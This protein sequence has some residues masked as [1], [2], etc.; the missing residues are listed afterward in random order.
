VPSKL[1]G[2]MRHLSK[3]IVPSV[4]NLCFMTQ[5][6]LTSSWRQPLADVTKNSFYDVSQTSQKTLFMT[7]AIG[8][9]HKKRWRARTLF[10]RHKTVCFFMTS[11][12]KSLQN[13][14]NSYEKES[15]EKNVW[16]KFPWWC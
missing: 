4:W 2:G 6:L 13:F 15:D 8:W 3:G 11:W 14:K 9:R 16:K 5:P 12:E 1:V 10:F 7:S